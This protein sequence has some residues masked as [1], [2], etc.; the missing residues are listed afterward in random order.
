MQRFLQLIK[1]YDMRGYNIFWKNLKVGYDYFQ[2][3][4]TTP[5]IKVDDNGKYLW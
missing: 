4:H 1:K 5:N 3:N 2:N